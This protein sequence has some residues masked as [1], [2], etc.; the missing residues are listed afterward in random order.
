MGTDKALEPV[1][2]VP[3]AARAAAALGAAGAINVVLVGA[4][5]EVAAAVGLSTV[6]DDDPGSGPLGGLA[7]ALAWAGA[8]V[9]V[10]AGDA[11]GDAP[12]EESGPEEAHILTGTGL[13]SPDA[14]AGQLILL[15]AACD[16]PALDAAGLADLVAALDQA[17]DDVVAAR[18]VTA[19]ERRHPL[20]SAW[21]VVGAL[22]PVAALHGAGERRIGAAF[23]AVATIEVASTGVDLVDLDTPSDVARWQDQRQPPR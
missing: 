17:D 14:P 20:P 11:A 7:T 22:D 6:P 9:A 19:D 5:D 8:A 1:D 13:A 21:R 3:M 16:Q 4:S 2:G 12:G 10:A 18:F 15:V 23:D